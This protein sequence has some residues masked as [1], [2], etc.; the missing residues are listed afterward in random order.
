MDPED[1]PLYGWTVFP[2]ESD[3]G[4][5]FGVFWRFYLEATGP[6]RFNYSIIHPEACF[7]QWTFGDSNPGPTGYRER[8]RFALMLADQQ[9]EVYN[10]V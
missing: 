10:G 4:T 6:N 1:F 3:A 7:C 8:S 5:Y 9:K 2:D